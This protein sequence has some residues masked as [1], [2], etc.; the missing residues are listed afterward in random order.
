MADIP[1]WCSFDKIVNLDSLIPNPVNPNVHPED[2]IKKLGDMIKYFGWRK[3]ITVSNLSGMVVRGHGRLQA[4]VEAGLKT[5]PVNFQ[6][7]ADQDEEYADLVADN[8]L[9]ELS[10]MDPDLTWEIVE[11]L[12]GAGFD[13]DLIGFDIGE[14]ERSRLTGADGVSGAVADGDLVQLPYIF[15][16]S[17]KAIIMKILNN[18]GDD[19]PDAALVDICKW[20]VFEYKL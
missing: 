3:S 18:P 7:Y 16:K 5:A 15:K 19:C 11:M 20:G 12:G 9:A 14:L 4:A 1:V 17:E 10:E 2:Q 13:I 8:K 6:D